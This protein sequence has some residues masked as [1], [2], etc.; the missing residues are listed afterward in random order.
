MTA[1]PR[2]SAASGGI[3]G[4]IRAD[5]ANRAAVTTVDCVD[6]AAGRLAIVLALARDRTGHHGQYGLGPGADSP[7]PGLTVRRGA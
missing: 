4:A 1:G 7:L 2:G 3:V 6:L 5:A